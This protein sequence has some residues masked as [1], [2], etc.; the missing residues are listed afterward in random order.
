MSFGM[1]KDKSS[2]SMTS[3][4]SVWGG[5]SPFLEALYGAAQG[6]QGQQ[7]G[8][9]PG[10][11]AGYAGEGLA[12]VRRGISSM[13]DLALTGGPVGQYANPNNA[14]AQEQLSQMSTNIGNEFQRNVLPGLNSAAGLAG[15]MG[16]SR[17]AIGRGLA[18]SDAQRQIAEAG[19]NLYANQYG[20]GAQAAGAATQARLDASGALPGMGESLYNLGMSP[21]TAQWAP[22]T[23]LAGILG[24]PTTLTKAQSSQSSKKSQFSFGL[25]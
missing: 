19:T 21:F 24:G 7:Q 12:G 4:Q 14:L 10:A 22:M 9:I 3:D 18:A 1:Q 16:G 5:Q 11:A 15:G 17:N 8:Q 6:L 13:S 23:A 20:I 2:A 25:F